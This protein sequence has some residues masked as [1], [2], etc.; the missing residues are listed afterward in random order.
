MKS[1]FSRFAA[2]GRLIASPLAESWRAV[3][4]VGATLGLLL[5]YLHQGSSTFFIGS[6]SHWFTPGARPLELQWWATIYQHIA[7]FVL[8]LIIPLIYLKG[9]RKQKFSE[10]GLG[11]GDWRFGFK[12]VAP[13]GILLVAIP[14]AI[15]ASFM[16]DFIAEYPLAKLAW[17]S[18]GNFIVYEL[19]YGLLYYTA[20]EAFFRGM[21]QFVLKE[22]IGIL[23]AILVQTSITT[24]LH[25][26]KP[27]GEIWSALFAGLIFGTLAFRLKSVWP[28]WII[29]FSLGFFTDLFC[30]VRGG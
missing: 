9:I 25:I 26:G 28:L 14:G 23:G 13:V 12:I 27:Q 20:Y 2:E 11:F 8:F 19:V 10:L 29:H 15:S 17:S 24:L 18:P 16:P 5:V 6:I 3:G 4:Y 22:R 1:F 21:L 30:S 7:A